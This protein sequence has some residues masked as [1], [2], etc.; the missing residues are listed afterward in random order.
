MKRHLIK[1]IGSDETDY[2][3][4]TYCGLDSDEWSE[5][6]GE[7][8]DKTLTRNRNE[9]TCKKCINACEKEMREFETQS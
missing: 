6:F 5:D 7:N 8:V 9:V 1:F 4:L 2:H 3:T